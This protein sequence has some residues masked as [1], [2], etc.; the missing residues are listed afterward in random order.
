MNKR[1]ANW[2]P[3]FGKNDGGMDKCCTFALE[4]VTKYLIMT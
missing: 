2:Q 3:F 4:L 1:A